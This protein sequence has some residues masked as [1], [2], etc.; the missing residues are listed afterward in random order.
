MQLQLTQVTDNYIRTRIIENDSYIANYLNLHGTE[1][2][3][4]PISASQTKVTLRIHY[5]RTL[6]PAWY[7]GPVQEFAI[8][9]SSEFLIDEIITP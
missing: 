7:F 3:L 1:I 4:E 8:A 5:Q 6:D 2:F 9:R